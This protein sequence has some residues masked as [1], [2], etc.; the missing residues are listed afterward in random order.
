MRSPGLPDRPWPGRR[1]HARR[2][3][4][5]RVGTSSK[6]P[7]AGGTHWR[8]TAATAC[9]PLETTRAGS[10]ARPSAPAS[11]PHAL[12]RGCREAPFCLLRL[13]ATTAPSWWIEAAA[14]RQLASV[15]GSREWPCHCPASRLCSLRLLLLHSQTRRRSPAAM[16]LP[17]PAGPCLARRPH[18]EQWCALPLPDLLQLTSQAAAQPAGRASLDAVVAAVGMLFSCPGYLL[19]A[20][21]LRQ[22]QQQQQQQQQDG[23]QGAAG[24]LGGTGPMDVDRAADVTPAQQGAAQQQAPEAPQQRGASD[25]QAPLSQ[26]QQQRAAAAPQRGKGCGGLDVPR[27]AATYQALL[28]LYDPAVVAALGSSCLRLLDSERGRG[29]CLVNT[30]QSRGGPTG[31]CSRP[32]GRPALTHTCGSCRADSPSILC[33]CTVPCEPLLQCWSAS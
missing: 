17:C 31:C 27:I 30:R 33:T 24:G 21:C 7:R 1:V 12:W 22:Q 28:R 11:S 4:P 3:L 14:W 25:P 32:C 18:G 2:C 9:W 15:S 20:L 6:S 26:Q 5:W 23:Q 29:S 10:A 13:G 8:S 16:R 19:E